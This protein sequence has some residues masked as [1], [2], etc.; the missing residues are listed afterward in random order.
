MRDI[1]CFFQFK[2]FVYP[3]KVEIRGA[4]PTQILTEP[5]PRDPDAVAP[6]IESARGIQGDEDTKR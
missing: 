1:L 3:D 2:V 5:E 4:I 6:I